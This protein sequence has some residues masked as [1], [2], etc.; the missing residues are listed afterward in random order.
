MDSHKHVEGVVGYYHNRAAEFNDKFLSFTVDQALGEL[1]RYLPVAPS[2]I[3]DVGAGPGRD[4]IW[5]A[6]Q[7][8]KVTAV[9]P[10]ESLRLSGQ[11]K[12]AELDV[13]WLDDRLPE[14]AVV[15]ARP[16]RFDFILLSAVWMFLPPDLRHPALQSLAGLL[17]P[18]GRIGMTVQTASAERQEL[19]FFTSTEDFA[20]LAKSA[21]LEIEA[22]FEVPDSRG[23]S[24][25]SWQSIVFCKA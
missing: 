5:L 18:H 15:A 19:K 4:A 9:E 12:S 24:S 6:Q 2:N 10:A 23:S 20:T 13:V 14:L 25:T 7:G 21:S 1:Q 8:H 16:T 17:K 11:Q 22:C 3:L